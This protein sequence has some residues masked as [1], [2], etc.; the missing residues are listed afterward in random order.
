MKRLNALIKDE[1]YMECLGKNSFYERDR[2]FCG[3]DFNHFL[4]TARITYIISLEEKL[5][6]TK[7]IIYAAAILH[8]IGR[9]KQYEENIPHNKASYD[10]AK[11]LLEKYSFQEEEKTMILDAILS[12]R[13]LDKNKNSLNALLYRG[14]KL[15]RMC[16]SCKATKECNWS[17][18]KKNLQIKY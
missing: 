14:D 4:D 6:F 1:L 3:H 16:I 5:S 13:V 2:V 8:D 9:F 7:E 10:I 17:E 12:H 11:Y 18:E 15:S